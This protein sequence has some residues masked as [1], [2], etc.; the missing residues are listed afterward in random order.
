[1]RPASS[2]WQEE[3]TRQLEALGFSTGIGSPCC[4]ERKQDGVACVV[5]GDDFTFEGPPEALEKIAADLK[6][7]WII[8]VRATLGPEKND[9]KEVS[10][11]N[12]IVR[13]TEDCLLYEA[14]PRRVEKLL[15]EA[16]LEECKPLGTPGVKEST[17]LTCTAW[18]EESGL[19]QGGVDRLSL[20]DS[21]PEAPELRPLDRE[22]MRRY[23]SAVARCNYLAHDR[24]EIAFTTKELCRAMSK[25]TVGD[26]KALARLCKFLK[27]LPRLVQRIPFEDCASFD[28]GLRRQRLGGMP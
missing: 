16:G 10:I 5:H 25:P 17:D 23:R 22:E 9:D 28:R 12:R 14:D 19:A 1:M 4:F 26:A 20:V 6:K 21:T 7:V 8:K 13:W 27:G 24:F 2:G 3:Y 15:K 11:L 18:F